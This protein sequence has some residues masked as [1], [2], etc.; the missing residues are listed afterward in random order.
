[1]T[2]QEARKLIEEDPNFVYLKRFNYSL[3]DL[4]A[5]HPDGVS[6]RVIAAALMMTEDDV[7][8][9]Y[10]SIVQKLRVAMKVE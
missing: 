4:V 1:L 5:R 3:A 6:D 2:G 9:M 8:D 7:A 10:A